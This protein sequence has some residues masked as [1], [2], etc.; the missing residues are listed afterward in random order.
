[1]PR[2]VIFLLL[3]MNTL[4]LLQPGRITFYGDLIWEDYIDRKGDHNSVASY[5]MMTLQLIVIC[6]AS[7]G[8]SFC[9]AV[10]WVVGGCIQLN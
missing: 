10:H 7:V 4:I 8:C 5:L 1:M 6:V 3:P 9:T 2:M